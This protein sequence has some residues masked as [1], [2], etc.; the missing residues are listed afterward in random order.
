MSSSASLTSGVAGRY[1]TALFELAREGNLEKVEDDLL[2]LEAAL[3][4]SGD[5]RDMIGSPVYRRDEQVSA[6][7]ELTTR[8]ALGSEVSNT[9]GLMAAN[10]RLFVLP[11]MIRNVKGLIAEHRGEMTA[12]VSAAKPLSEAQ[13]A[14]LSDSLKS[15]VGKNVKLDVT[16]DESLIGGMVVRLGSRMIDTSIRA[17]LAN[18]QNIMKEVG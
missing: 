10:R 6:L 17:K 16:V 8:M 1:A 9:V 7:R 15:S 13:I 4:E 14:A 11:E 18:L 12:Q 5:L 2:A 3:S